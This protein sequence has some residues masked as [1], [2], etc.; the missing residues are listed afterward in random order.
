VVREPGV[1]HGPLPNVE[2]IVTVGI[3]H[4]AAALAAPPRRTAPSWSAPPPPSWSPGLGV[5]ARSLSPGTAPAHAGA[6]GHV[7]AHTLRLLADSAH[8]RTAVLSPTGAVLHLGRTHRL[9]P[10]DLRRA[11]TARD[12]GCIIPGCAVP[13]H[14]C[15]AHHVVP[16]ADGGPTDIDN[17]ALLCVRHHVEVTAALAT[18]GGNGWEITMADGVPWVRPPSWIDRHRPLLRNAV[19]HPQD[20]RL[21]EG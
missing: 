17:T 12:L 10:P 16:W 13:A 18:G 11:L 19:H 8:L 1:R 4:L 5:L 7:D 2:I 20:H 21:T 14:A 6:A 3:E 9:V 15:Q